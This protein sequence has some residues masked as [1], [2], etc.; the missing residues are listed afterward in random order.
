MPSSSPARTRSPERTITDGA[1]AHNEAL[2]V[3]IPLPCPVATMEWVPPPKSR[4]DVDAVCETAGPAAHR[5]GLRPT[6][7]LN[8]SQHRRPERLNRARNPGHRGRGISLSRAGV[9][10]TI[11]R[12]VQQS[13]EKKK[14]LQIGN[15]SA[16]HY[17]TSSTKLIKPILDFSVTVGG[18]RPS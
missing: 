9:T 10:S 5:K 16:Q 14:T 17:F 1:L 7:R 18:R 4:R 15:F 6:C 12:F 13:R 11:I 3:Q 8:P 2:R